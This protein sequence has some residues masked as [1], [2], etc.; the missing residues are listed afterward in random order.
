MSVYGT[1]E[2][3]QAYFDTR[4]HTD[5]WDELGDGDDAVITKNKAL[6][7]ATRIIDRL[8]Y[9]GTPLT[10]SNK[11]PQIDQ[12]EVPTYV[13][14]ACYEIVLSLLDGIDPDLELSNLAQVSTQYANIKSTR[15]SNQTLEH[16]LAGVPSQTAWRLLRP[17]LA[18]SRSV[19]LV[20][21]S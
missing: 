18:D 2:L 16:I 9:S 10:P 8:E 11:F 21:G 15:D 12:S 13:L 14:E 7:H 1:I 4:L 3:A 20:R 19:T 6:A 17:Y 5:A